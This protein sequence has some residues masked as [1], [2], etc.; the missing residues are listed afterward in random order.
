MLCSQVFIAKPDDSISN[1]SKNTQGTSTGLG[2]QSYS[3]HSSPCLY[4]HTGV[5]SG[6]SFH[7]SS[8][9]EYHGAAGE[10]QPHDVKRVT[11]HFYRKE[12]KTKQTPQSDPSQRV[13][14]SVNFLYEVMCYASDDL[15]QAGTLKGSSSGTEGF[16]NQ[17]REGCIN[18]EPTGSANMLILHTNRL[19]SHN[20]DHLC[21]EVSNGLL[22]KGWKMVSVKLNNG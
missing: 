20:R 2:L 15:H 17:E 7:E 18:L 3:L 16:R 11:S 10:I 14:V 1:H 4:T 22:L 6:L 9:T 13:R 19:A 8:F 21:I 5:C 12:P